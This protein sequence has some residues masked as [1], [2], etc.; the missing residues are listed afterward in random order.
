VRSN[1]L[2]LSSLLLL[3]VTG[4]CGYQW[5]PELSLG[6]RPVIAVPF[7]AGDEE[8][9]LT[10]E[11]IARLTSSGLAKVSTSKGDFRLALKT[12]GSSNTQIG[13][14]RDPQ[15]IKNE[16]QKNLLATEL[17]KTMDIEVTLFHGS[18]ENI[19][20]GPFTISAWADFDYVD[21][22]SYQDLT[23]ERPSAIFSPVLPFSLGQLED[24]ESAEL[25]V[26]KPLY[27]RLAQKIVDVI[28]AEW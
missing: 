12:L 7:I 13:Y 14:R 23:F 25:A 20:Y 22:D 4:G 28:S 16:I 10:Q 3:L 17:R 15:K 6:H 5:Y 18:T 27:S 11:I 21:G 24:R 9:L 19:A 2:P 8:G 26:V 1:L